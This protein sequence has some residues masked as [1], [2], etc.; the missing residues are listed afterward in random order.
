MEKTE[1]PAFNV[2]PATMYTAASL[3]IMHILL[4]VA[5]NETV[6]WV[7]GLLAFSTERF[8]DFLQAPSGEAFTGVLVTLF[9][10]MFLH[11][12]FM[13]LV[14]NAFM[15]LA[16]G[17]FVE[18]ARGMVGFFLLFFFCGWVGAIAEY[19][20]TASDGVSF[21]YGA[22]GGVFGMMGAATWLLLPR[23][24]ARK[25]FAFAGVMLGLNLVIALTP[26]GNLLTGGEASISW[27]AHMAGF[28]LG[29]VLLPLLPDRT[30]RQ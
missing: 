15:L 5:N 22:S 13:H 25:V 27:A 4:T 21:L 8:S 23:F 28:L 11:N 17:A 26:L 29:V 3:I 30:I 20:V 24:G 19:L 16:F 14:M 10:H 9:G 12:D 18:R 6:N 7:Y 1:E 2:P